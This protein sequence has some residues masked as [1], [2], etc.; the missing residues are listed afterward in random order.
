MSLYVLADPLVVE[1]F[2][3]IGVPGQTPHAEENLAASIA[4]LARGAG[5]RLVLV[6]E[7]I[8]TRLA[9]AD[10]DR[11]AGSFS[12]AV[13]PIPGLAGAA[14]DLGSFRSQLQALIGR[15]A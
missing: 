7:E 8:A 13:V 6:Q 11:L 14:P 5:V 1:A 10:L 4:D 9:D 12:C 15:T 3:L 2:S